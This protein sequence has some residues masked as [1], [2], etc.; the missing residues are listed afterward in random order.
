MRVAIQ[1]PE[2]TLV[3]D[4]DCSKVIATDPASRPTSRNEGVQQQVSKTG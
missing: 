3:I 1:G 4:L 2:G